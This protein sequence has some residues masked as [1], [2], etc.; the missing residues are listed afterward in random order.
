MKK[1][2]IVT[3]NMEAGGAERVIAQLIKEW[4][5]QKYC[6]YL[7]L[8]EK[9]EVFYE[10]PKN[11]NIYTIGLKNENLYVDKFMKYKAIRKII[12]N[13]KPDIVLS[14]PEEVG[15]Y[16]ILAMIGTKIPVFVSERNN[17]W[18]MPYK[19]IT[20]LLRR[21]AYPLAKGVIFQTEGAANYFSKRI[22]KKGVVLSNPL[23]LSRIPEE[24]RGLRKKII[25]SAGRL[26]KQ[27]N[28]SILIEAF[29]IYQKKHPEYK[30]IIYGEGSERKILEELAKKLL[31][32]GTYL[33]PGKRS[34]LLDEI[35]DA[36]MFILSS[37][38]EGVPNVL[39][40]AM[41][42]GLPVI[43]TDSM[44][45]GSDVLIKNGINGLLIPKNNINAML[46]AMEKYTEDSLF[47]EKLGHA[48]VEIKEK[49]DSKKVSILW[50]KYM[51]EGK[52][53]E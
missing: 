45:G 52:K 3:R 7:I 40:E 16:V 43:S 15:I 53:V 32:K 22:R 47:A 20:R 44:P 13:I 30:L 33:F 35:K 38:Y 48:A 50:L 10:L 27:K 46:S 9:S 18:I 36:S 23:D 42:V 26:E 41:A 11:L 6:C 39:I 34:N 1:I 5:A 4:S 2:V 25:V 12:K 21:I 31:K 14:L 29:S 19:K 28:F 49:M 8:L 24:Y 37:D 51:F 17:P